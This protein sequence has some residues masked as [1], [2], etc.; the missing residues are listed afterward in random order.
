MSG[1]CKMGNSKVLKKN[2]EINKLLSMIFEFGNLFITN[3][4][5]ILHTTFKAY[6]IIR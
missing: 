2:L 1:F 3:W 5:I 4:Y 6:G